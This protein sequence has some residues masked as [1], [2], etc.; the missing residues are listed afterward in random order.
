MSY[1]YNSNSGEYNPL[2]NEVV[3]NIPPDRLKTPI[4]ISNIRVGI[5][6]K[7]HSIRANDWEEPK[8]E[9]ND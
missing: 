7:I 9:K 2:K 3:W 8:K 4:W 5:L 1:L 6:S